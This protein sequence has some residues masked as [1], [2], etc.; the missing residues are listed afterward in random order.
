M[1]EPM[2]LVFL[3][4]GDPLYLPEMMDRVL[5]R[6]AGETPAVFVVPPL[7]R[8]ESSRHAALRYAR[9]FGFRA[10]V[11]LA[12][13]VL[14]ARARR[15]SIESV[16]RRRGVACATARQVNA[17]E[18]LDELRR[19]APDV[20]VSVSCPQ[21]FKPALIE[22]PRLGILNVH[23][24]ALP[25]YRGVMPSFW[26]LL[27]GES[28]AGVSV[29]FVDA[30]IDTGDLCGQRTFDILPEESLDAFLRRSKRIAAELLIEVL[31]SIEAGRLSRRAIDP[32]EG[33]YY[34]WPDSGAVKRF[35]RAGRR[36]W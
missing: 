31:E 13:R 22:V 17:P 2:R 26:M 32:A 36:L 24:A 23:G 15:Q 33:S 20:V 5:E 14:A 8:R 1:A 28:Q 11:H 21:V 4:A 35:R 10:T 30:G 27:N 12:A 29:H 18:F 16:C 6:F 19:M 9:T 34:G 25:K 7:Y 3:V